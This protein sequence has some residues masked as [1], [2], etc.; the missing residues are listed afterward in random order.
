MAKKEEIRRPRRE[1]DGIEKKLIEVRRVTKVVK[2]GRTMRF[3][4][5]VAVGDKNGKVGIGLGKASEVPEAIEKANKQARKNM[6]SVAIVDGTIPHDYVG[7]Y[8]TCNI[9][10]KSAKEGTGIIAGGSA[11]D[12]IELAGIKNIVTKVHGS[13]NRINCA[14]ATING[15]KALRT[16]EEIAALRNKPVEEI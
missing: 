5:L 2:G 9:L 8:S 11:R 13:N 12:V 15:L 1:D 3:S 10:M 14:K 6:I 16:K 4:A 7:K